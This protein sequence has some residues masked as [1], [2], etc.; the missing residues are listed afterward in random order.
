MS[1]G[2]ATVIMSNDAEERAVVTASMNAI[3][4]GIAAGAQVAQFPATGAPRWVMGFKACLGTTV[5][6]FGVILTIL[7]LS[8]RDERKVGVKAEGDVEVG[9]E[10]EGVRRDGSGKG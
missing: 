2:W 9:G 8:R 5:A 3:G 1:M 6:Q 10:G 4:Q 7:Y